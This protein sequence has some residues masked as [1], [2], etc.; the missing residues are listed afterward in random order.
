MPAEDTAIAAPRWP[1]PGTA[2]AY[3]LGALQAG[4][5]LTAQ[6]AYRECGAMRLA[7]IVYAL[8]RMGWP[9]VAVDTTVP[10][11]EGRS[12]RVSRYSIAS[13]PK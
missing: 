2:R 5:A 10:C 12:A 3:V 9:I 4:Y 7:A 6:D 11:R 13:S 1:K 8:R